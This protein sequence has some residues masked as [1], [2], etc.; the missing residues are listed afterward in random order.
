MVVV[1]QFMKAPQNNFFV[2]LCLPLREAGLAKV[3]LLVGYETFL[4]IKTFRQWIPK[5]GQIQN[6]MNM[7]FDYPFLRSQDKQGKLELMVDEG[8]P[9]L[10]IFECKPGEE[11]PIRR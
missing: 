7:E 1:Q 3:Y 4:E 2:P 11:V 10:D 6:A 5:L 9:I 8:S